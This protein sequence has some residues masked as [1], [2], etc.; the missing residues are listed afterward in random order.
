MSS[1]NYYVYILTNSIHSVFYTG[2]TNN[3]P[4]RIYQHKNKIVSGFTSKYNIWKLLYYEIYE[5]VNDA[6]AREKQVKDY[7]REKKLAMIKTLNPQF[8]DLM[9]KM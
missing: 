7:R 3:L 9:E 2:M 6:I 4:L 5:D 8:K 1:K